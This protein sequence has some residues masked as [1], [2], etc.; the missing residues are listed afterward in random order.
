M[1]KSERFLSDNAEKKPPHNMSYVVG[2]LLDVLV[3]GN[4]T[5]VFNHSER[6]WA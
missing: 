5:E 6:R 2:W 3:S 1:K 4:G